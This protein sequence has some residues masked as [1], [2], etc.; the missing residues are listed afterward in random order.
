MDMSPKG[1]SS[2][3]CYYEKDFSE[4]SRV[5]EPPPAFSIGFWRSAFPGDNSDLGAEA[6]EFARLA[7]RTPRQANFPAVIDQSMAQ[8]DPLAAR[9][10][11]VEFALDADGIL[12]QG[13]AKAVAQAFDMGI[14]HHPIGKIERIAKNDVG[15]FSADTGEFHEVVNQ[16]GDF[17]AV[18][19]RHR[20]GHGLE[21]LGLGSKKA[22]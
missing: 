6:R 7:P 4:E 18:N 15:G 16:T 5:A 14:N 1:V 10:D 2:E 21:I 19:G 20:F 22:G 11:C 9:D 8:I 13:K 3:H 17:A 12:P